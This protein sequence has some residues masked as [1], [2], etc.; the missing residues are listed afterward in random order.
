MGS[1]SLKK[2]DGYV[3]RKGGDI[4]RADPRKLVEDWNARQEYGDEKDLELK[5]SIAANG[6]EKPLYVQN[7]DNQLVVRDGCRRRWACLELIKE[8]HDIKAVPVTLVDRNMSPARATMMVLSSSTSKPLSPFEEAC[9]V[10]RLLNFGWT[11]EEIATSWGKSVSHVKNRVKL[12]DAGPD[13]RDGL[14]NGEIGTSDAVNAISEAGGDPEKQKKVISQIKTRK[15]RLRIVYDKRSS[16]L[17]LKGKFEEGQSLAVKPIFDKAF[18]NSL[19]AAGLDVE[20]I[21]FSISYK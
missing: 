13:I 14:K 8:G 20:T 4:F 5:A 15:K 7:V 19:E 1:A 9:A 3:D 6:V 18:L 2:I 21:Q 17:K 16:D 11:H 12:I 10:K